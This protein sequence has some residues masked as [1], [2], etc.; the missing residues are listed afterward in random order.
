[1]VYLYKKKKKNTCKYNNIMVYSKQDKGKEINQMKYIMKKAAYIIA[2]IT[3][4][5]FLI[6]LSLATGI[7]F[8]M[9]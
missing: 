5:P 4:A 3:L 8:Y 1:M 2:K 9:D 7:N 6:V